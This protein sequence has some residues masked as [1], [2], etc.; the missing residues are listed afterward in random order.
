MASVLPTL[1]VEVVELIAG[2][3]D[4]DAD[5][6]HLR[7]VCGELTSKTL[8]Y[9]RRRCFATVRTDFTLQS[10][11]KLQDIS[12]EERLRHHV[13]TLLIKQESDGEPEKKCHRRPDAHRPRQP[14]GSSE[15]LLHILETLPNILLNNLPNCRSF[16]IQ[17]HSRVALAYKSPLTW[18][19]DVIE[20]VFSTIAS[21]SLP[22]KS[23]FV[24]LR[25]RGGGLV[26]AHQI[27]TIYRQPGFRRGWAHLQE[28]RLE[29]SASML[30]WD[31]GLDLVSLAPNLR[32]LWLDLEYRWSGVLLQHLVDFA[33]ISRGLRDFRLGNGYLWMEILERF[34]RHVGDSL[35]SLSIWHVNLEPGNGT[36]PMLFRQMRAN[37][38]RLESF[39]V[40]WLEEHERD[41]I[42]K[43]VFPTLVDS[44][45][46]PGPRGGRYELTYGTWEEGQDVIGA[47]YRGPEMDAALETVAKSI[48][49]LCIDFVRISL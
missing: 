42:R 9:F 6:F 31:G 41:K 7:L 10:L 35:R 44:P 39:S 22:V 8:N 45:T 19:T 25:T 20:I 12:Q 13:Q 43:V 24:D 26:Y 28:L 18:P 23:F 27:K 32:M 4:H 37:L 11:Q 49:Y 46:V 30:F 14:L 34:F 38:P 29:P 21:T 47:S 33:E 17:S 5:L 2:A 48:Q 16:H 1:P 36:W 15:T 40:E 3:L